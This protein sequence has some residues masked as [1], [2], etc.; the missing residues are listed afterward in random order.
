MSP[1]S[2]VSATGTGGTIQLI[3]KSFG[4]CSNDATRHCIT[5]ADCT[6]GCNTGQCLNVNPDT[7]GTTAQFSPAPT[8][9][10]DPSLIACQ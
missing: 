6:V 8:F 2:H 10:E 7:G 4:T 1:T 3:T 5:A 9:I